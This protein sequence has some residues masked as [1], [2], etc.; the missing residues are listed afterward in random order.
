MKAASGPAEVK[1]ISTDVTAAASVP[2]SSTLMN[3][4]CLTSEIYRSS[5]GLMPVKSA[6]PEKAT[7]N[8]SA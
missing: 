6:W 1:R 8:P 7:P 5:S 3:V 2:S 4:L